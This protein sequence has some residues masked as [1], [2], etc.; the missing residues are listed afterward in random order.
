MLSIKLSLFLNSA[1]ANKHE[2]YTLGCTRAFYEYTL[3][4]LMSMEEAC[5]ECILKLKTDLLTATRDRMQ[6]PSYLSSKEMNRSY[7]ICCDALN[8]ANDKVLSSCYT[9]ENI[10]VWNLE[11]TRNVIAKPPEFMRT[12]F[13]ESDLKFKHEM[14]H[15]RSK[16]FSLPKKR[17]DS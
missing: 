15:L 8:R 2:Q 4:E 5:E 10:P 6:P 7:E 12:Q 9:W 13:D 1:K 14:V 3:K 16:M 11:D 17:N